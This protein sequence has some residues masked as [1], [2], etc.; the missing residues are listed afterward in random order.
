MGTSER[1][2]EG[3]VVCERG[4]GGDREGEK[5]RGRGRGRGRGGEREGGRKRR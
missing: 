3:R 4:E 1:L 2:R 5:V